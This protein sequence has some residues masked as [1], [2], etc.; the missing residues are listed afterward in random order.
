M[1]KTVL[2]TG[3]A[4]FIGSHLADELL[5][6]GYNVRALDNLS[7]QVHGKNCV[8]PEYLNEEV[9]LIVGDVR[10]PEAVKKALKGVDAV[11]HYAALVG[12]GQSMYQ[13]REYTDV[14]NNGTA[15]LLEALV[16]NPV[17]KLIVASS[18]SI[19]GEGLYKTS[20]G[21]IMPGLDRKL[22]QLKK[23]DWEV[24]DE[25]GD[26]LTPYPTPETKKPSLASIYA[27]SKYDQ[28][29]MCLLIGQAY[30]IPTV[31][32]RFFNVYGTN[33]ALSN[34]YTGVLAIFASRLL[35]GNAPM[36]FEDGRQHR[37]FVSVHDI[38]QA[39]RLALE[40][41]AAKYEAFNVGSGNAY[42]VLEIAEKMARVLGKEDLEVEISGK[43][44]VGD[45]RHCFADISKA[46]EILNYQPSI[47]L[48][49]GLVELASWLEGQTAVDN[50]AHARN[51]LV[52]RGLT[53]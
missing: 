50:V 12:V 27:L 51:E 49:E 1:S 9:E 41:E 25:N 16:N 11:Y 48:E 14:N 43:Y 13:I 35:N 32:L 30:N 24:R 22:E 5:E 44:R 29:R 52:T 8:R 42:T 6:K 26:V 23:S 2:I 39:S 20:E 40:T 53:V 21:R 45:I 18:M 33:Q 47:S 10:D 46:K 7:E 17:E 3:G 4:G 36:I 28:E 37:D 19:Y 38:A 34:P 15:V 31:A